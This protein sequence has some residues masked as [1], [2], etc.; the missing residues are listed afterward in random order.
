MWKFCILYGFLYLC[1]T[2]P[3]CDTCRAHS[4]VN[5]WHHQRATGCFCFGQ[6]SLMLREW[7]QV[8]YQHN[9]RCHFRSLYR[10]VVLPIIVFFLLAYTYIVG[11]VMSVFTSYFCQS[12][13][14]LV[15]LY[16][17]ISALP[18]IISIHEYR[19]SGWL[20]QQEDINRIVLYQTDNSMTPWTQRCIR[21]ADCILI[22]G[23]G[24]QEPA[25]GEVRV[26]TV[27][28]REDKMYIYTLFIF[29]PSPLLFFSWS[30]C[31]K[32]QQSGRWNS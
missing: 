32:T 11:L 8:I 13:S 22:V 19:L 23:L 27:F 2:L 15:I 26:Y 10:L 7:S 30:R 12:L 21:Q 18:S 28:E 5:Q 9:Y 17:H 4:A 1:F 16:L 25:L 14:I 31:W 29:L 3:L 6:V 20:A 24:D